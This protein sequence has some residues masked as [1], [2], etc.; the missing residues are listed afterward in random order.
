MFPGDL[1]LIWETKSKDRNT[2]SVQQTSFAIMVRQLLASSSI[3][4]FYKTYLTHP[5]SYVLWGIQLPYT[6]QCLLSVFNLNPFPIS[7]F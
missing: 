2:L 4:A 7:N 3:S 5:K 6:A 1:K